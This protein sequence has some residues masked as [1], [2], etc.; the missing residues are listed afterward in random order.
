MSFTS[1]PFAC[2]SVSIVAGD[3]HCSIERPHCFA[4]TSQGGTGFDQGPATETESRALTNPASG[5]HYRRA[6]CSC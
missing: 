5:S 3:L 4:E 6:R 2:L 1:N